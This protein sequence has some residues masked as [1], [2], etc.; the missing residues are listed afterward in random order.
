MP[1]L[2]ATDLTLPVR[3]TVPRQPSRGTPNPGIKE[4]TQAGIEKVPPP[5]TA[6]AKNDDTS[7]LSLD[8]T[9]GDPSANDRTCLKARDQLAGAGRWTT[10]ATQAYHC[11]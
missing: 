10:T 5:V 8:G 7:V 4:L 2:T 9:A 6:T 1:R 11:K 3:G